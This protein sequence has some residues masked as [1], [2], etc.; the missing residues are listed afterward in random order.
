MD[1]AIVDLRDSIINLHRLGYV[2]ALSKVRG[3]NSELVVARRLSGFSPVIDSS[4]VFL[5]TL[6]KTVEVKSNR[7]YDPMN[8]D[9]EYYWVTT[10]RQYE[11]RVLIILS[12]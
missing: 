8:G 7:R 11:K 4:D 5:E 3:I 1:S 10:K 6:D 12:S 2:G 9:S